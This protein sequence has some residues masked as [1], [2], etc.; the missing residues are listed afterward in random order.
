MIDVPEELLEA[1]RALPDGMMGELDDLDDLAQERC[2]EDITI[3]WVGEQA[4]RFTVGEKSCFLQQSEDYPED[5][6][7]RINH[8]IEFE[9]ELPEAGLSEAMFELI[10]LTVTHPIEYAQLCAGK[11]GTEGPLLAQAISDFDEKL[12]R[13]GLPPGAVKIADVTET[14][15]DFTIWNTN[16][17]INI[18][19]EGEA[20]TLVGTGD[21][22]VRETIGDWIVDFRFNTIKDKEA[23]SELAKMSRSVPV[24]FDDDSEDD[25]FNVLNDHT[26]EQV[27]RFSRKIVDYVPP[28]D[29]V[30]I[31]VTYANEGYVKFMFG[32]HR[33]DMSLDSLGVAR[34]II[35]LDDVPLAQGFDCTV[36]KVAKR[37]TLFFKTVYKTSALEVAMLTLDDF[38]G[39]M[40]AREFVRRCS[41][42]YWTVDWAAVKG[43]WRWANEDTKVNLA[44]HNCE[45]DEIVK[46][47]ESML[48]HSRIQGA[49]AR[50][51]RCGETDEKIRFMVGEHL[52]LYTVSEYTD[53]LFQLSV[54]SDRLTHN[55][56]FV[57]SNTKVELSILVM[58]AL[59]ELAPYEVLN[60][61]IEKIS[62]WNRRNGAEDCDNCV[63]VWDV[64]NFNDLFNDCIA[65]HGSVYPEC[66]CEFC[67][68]Q[69]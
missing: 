5:Y 7:F 11:F 27:Y 48:K 13:A 23:G 3:E 50:L 37:L 54:E 34:T 26:R 61:E 43:L 47:V 62:E 59:I 49:A 65:K 8:G 24:K 60:N 29:E 33:V 57:G 18:D 52:F 67:G 68:E 30:Q 20:H 66:G 2:Q 14:S 38:Y 64:Y 4:V 53:S 39:G 16:V 19:D 44:R 6:Y 15:I 22:I 25:F 55:V 51:K 58:A 9:G 46:D 10:G 1:W 36:A 35:R 56:Y 21:T 63:R 69:S 42:T 45:L 32:P 40:D 31:R 12:E 28:A 41:E 17:I